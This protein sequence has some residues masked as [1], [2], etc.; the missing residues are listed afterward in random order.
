MKRLLVVLG[1]SFL[2]H[3]QT[4]KPMKSFTAIV[5]SYETFATT[6]C[7]DT[8]W[9]DDTTQ[10]INKFICD[11]LVERK[12]VYQDISFD[13]HSNEIIIGDADGNLIYGSICEKT[14]W[15]LVWTSDGF[16]YDDCQLAVDSDFGTWYVDYCNKTLWIQSNDILST[17]YKLYDINEH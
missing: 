14:F 17:N 5:K 12:Q 16:V 8:I 6:N 13:F 1:V 9:I 15:Y 2:G 10:F 3:T 11:S 7:T 4:S